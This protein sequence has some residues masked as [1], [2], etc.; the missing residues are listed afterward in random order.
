MTAMARPL[1]LTAILG[2]IAASVLEM[3]S[4]PWVD[5]QET[6]AVYP[7]STHTVKC[8]GFSRMAGVINMDGWTV[9]PQSSGDYLI[10]TRDVPVNALMVRREVAVWG[11]V[12]VSLWCP[13]SASQTA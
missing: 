8:L 7:Q 2:L 3:T 13:I 12:G 1:M 10:L 6:P 5:R 4:L 9:S 11:R